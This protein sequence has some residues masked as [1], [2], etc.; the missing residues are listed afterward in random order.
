[1]YTVIFLDVNI[2]NMPKGLNFWISAILSKQLLME[3]WG[4]PLKVKSVKT[5]HPF[6]KCDRWKYISCG[7]QNDVGESFITDSK[8]HLEGSIKNYDSEYS[9][10]MD[11]IFPYVDE[12]LGKI[13]GHIRSEEWGHPKNIVVSKEGLIY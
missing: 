10:F 9:K 1:M 3:E 4:Y 13:V 2:R 7:M 5:Y 12:P 11:L 8:L 6:F